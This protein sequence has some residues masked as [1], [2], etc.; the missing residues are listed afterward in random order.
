MSEL[1]YSAS[2]K[3]DSTFQLLHCLNACTVVDLCVLNHRCL[4]ILGYNQAWR[5][6]PSNIKIYEI[7]MV[8]YTLTL[9]VSVCMYA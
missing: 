9:R 1:A 4:D 7:Y 6:A 5:H 2:S 8:S 3:V